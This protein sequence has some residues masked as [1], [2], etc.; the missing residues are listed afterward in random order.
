MGSK[1]SYCNGLL[2]YGVEIIAVG[3]GNAEGNGFEVQKSFSKERNSYRRLVFKGDFLVGA[4]LVQAIDK[5]GIYTNLIKRK[6]NVAS[7][8]KELIKDDFS[9]ISLPEELRR[10]WMKDV[11]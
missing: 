9:L 6:E 4:I 10:N 1:C 7:F 2:F 5:A 8:R 11:N 3:F